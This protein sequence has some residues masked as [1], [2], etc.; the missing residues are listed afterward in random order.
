MKK[1]QN[2][3]HNGVC[4][5]ENDECDF[6]PNDMD[7]AAS[8]MRS[9]I[10]QVVDECKNRFCTDRDKYIVAALAQ[11]GPG[12]TIANMKDV[13]SY[14]VNDQIKWKEWYAYEVVGTNSE[15]EYRKHW[16]LFY[17]YAK[18]LNV[19]GYPL[20]SNILNDE[21]VLWLKSQ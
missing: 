1:D 2:G 6:R 15:E 3:S 13:K 21:I 5:Q 4:P 19:E 12:F 17:K 10:K 11:N 8:A 16:K 20:P 18:G 14:V 7:W 9:R